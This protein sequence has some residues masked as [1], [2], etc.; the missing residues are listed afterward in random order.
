MALVKYLLEIALTTV[1]IFFVWNILKRLFLKS[2]YRQ[3]QREHSKQKSFQ[4]RKGQPL[5]W[6]AETVDFEEIPAKKSDK[7]TTENG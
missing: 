1:I 2:F 6:D 3:P 4:K 7:P 5:N